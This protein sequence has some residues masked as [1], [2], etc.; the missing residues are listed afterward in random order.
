MKRFSLGIVMASVLA[1]SAYTVAGAQPQRGGPGMGPRGDGPGAG[2]GAMMML[3]GL[4]LSEQQRSEARA[5]LQEERGALGAVR[6]E[7]QLH[8]QLQAELL[9]DAPDAQKL[10][11]LQQQLTEAHAN[12]LAAQINV[13]Q[14]LAQVLT[15]EQRATA[16]ERLAEAPQRGVG[17]RGP[18]GRRARPQAN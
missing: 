14:R 9:A 17:P 2:R 1:L 16:R 7:V 5:I 6:T 10:A 11:E 8:R 13:G 18:E 3:R 4:D 15:P 12:R